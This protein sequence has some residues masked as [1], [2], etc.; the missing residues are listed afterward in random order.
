MP[1]YFYQIKGR[2][3]DIHDGGTGWAWPPVFS[4]L[5][6]ASDRKEAKALIEEEYSR[7]FPVRV[8]KKDMEQHAY[9]LLIR[10]VKP[11]E[12]YLLRRF[13]DTECKECQVIFKPI[14]KYNDPH[15]DHLGSEY[16]SAKCSTAGRARDL[17]EFK[18]AGLGKSPPVI[19]QVRQKSTGKVYIGQTVRSFTLRWWEHLSVSTGCKFH[20]ALRK[21]Q[22]TDWEFSVIEVIEPPSD[23]PD[24]TAYIS[25]RERYW[26]EVKNS[27][28][29]GFNSVLPMG[30]SP[31][32]NLV[33]ETEVEE[34]W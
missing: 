19:Y 3:S 5:V 34:A 11:H 30:I 2:E 17:L 31:Q 4:G 25:D 33:L 24:K 27:V 28:L 6:V 32:S 21:T 26:V 29:D 9:L 1:D 23:C 16:C 20:E 22:I 15:C 10:E 18:L 7:V 14:D 8:L 12:E 13:R